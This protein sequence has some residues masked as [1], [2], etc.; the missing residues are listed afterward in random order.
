MCNA[1]ASLAGQAFGVGAGTVGAFAGAKAQQASLRSQARIAEINA[2]LADA[3]ARGELMAS[4]RQ[5]SSIK[6]RGAQVKA[7]QRAA[8]AANGIDIGVG[9]PVDIATSTDYFTEVDANT[10]RANGIQAAWGRRIQ[11]GNFRREATSA[12]ATAKGISPLLAGATTLISGAS[13]VAQSW[14]SL[15]KVGAIGGQQQGG[16]TPPVWGQPGHE[17]GYVPFDSSLPGLP[18]NQDGIRIR[19]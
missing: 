9:T 16:S 2:T 7:S 11:A 14:Y 5:Q 15:S 12:R 19:W 6:L 3:A 18:T 13:Q 4:E 1:T 8:T 10:A 17:G